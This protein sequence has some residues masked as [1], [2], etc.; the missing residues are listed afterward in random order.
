MEKKFDPRYSTKSS[1]MEDEYFR[2]SSIVPGSDANFDIKNL[3]LNRQKNKSIEVYSKN[4]YSKSD[5]EIISV[6][7]KGAYAK[8]VK[9]KYLKDNSFKAIKIIEKSFIERV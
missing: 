9:A 7:G 5:F 6:L 3:L 1:Y 4:T 2:N 8:V